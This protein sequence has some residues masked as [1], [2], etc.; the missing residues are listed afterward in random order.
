VLLLAQG[1]APS[2]SEST[3]D[4]KLSIVFLAFLLVGTPALLCLIYS[5]W[6]I[7]WIEAILPPL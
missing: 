3:A 5:G 4:F 7:S 2:N 6:C 1:M